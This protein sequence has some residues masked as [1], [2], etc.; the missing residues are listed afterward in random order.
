MKSTVSTVFTITTLGMSA[1]GLA[2]VTPLCKFGSGNSCLVTISHV[3]S[4]VFERLLT[5]CLNAIAEKN[6]P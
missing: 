3:L 1:G 4:K 6:I 2:I 5:M